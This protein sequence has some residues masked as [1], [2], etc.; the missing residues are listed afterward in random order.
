MMLSQFILAL[1]SSDLCTRSCHSLELFKALLF[2]Y[3]GG[4]GFG[5]HLGLAVNHV[6]FAQWT[7]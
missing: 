7:R 4:F 3:L 5:F 6:E 2:V 1:F